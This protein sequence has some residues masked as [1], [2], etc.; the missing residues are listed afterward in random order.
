[1]P[2]SRQGGWGKAHRRYKT[3]PNCLSWAYSPIVW[4]TW[5]L[6]ELDIEILEDPIVANVTGVDNLVENFDESPKKDDEDNNE[7]TLIAM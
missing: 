5:E 6:I 2:W 3:L 7:D 1:M 4:W